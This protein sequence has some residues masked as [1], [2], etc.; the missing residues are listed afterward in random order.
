MMVRGGRRGFRGLGDACS[1][2]GALPPGA[3]CTVGADGTPNLSF[4]AAATGSVQ[5][6]TPTGTNCAAIQ[7]ALAFDP[8]L[9]AIL[10]SSCGAAASSN[11]GTVVLIGSLLFVLGIFAF[12]R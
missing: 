10:P 3:S 6:I 11:I 12:S 9:A 7:Q 2:L 5:T 4:T 8:S 1:D